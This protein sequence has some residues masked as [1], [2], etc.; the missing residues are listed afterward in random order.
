M[1][2]LNNNGEYIILSEPSKYILEFNKEEE[3]VK[4]TYNQILKYSD[5]KIIIHNKFSK[6]PLRELLKKAYAFVSYQSTAGLKAI[7]EGV[8]AYFTYKS[9]K[10]FGSLENINDRNLNYDLLYL[11]TNSQWKLNEFFSEDFKKYMNEIIRC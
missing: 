7:I 11:A 10:K 4:K 2:E 1:K 6:E 9:L 3:W 5:R 8:P